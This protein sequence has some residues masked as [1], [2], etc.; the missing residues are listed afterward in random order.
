MAAFIGT[1]TEKGGGD[2][3]DAGAMSGF[4]VVIWLVAMIVLVADKF[5]RHQMH[6]EATTSNIEKRFPFP[7]GGSNNGE[8]P[9]AKFS[10]GGGH[11]PGLY[12]ALL[13]FDVKSM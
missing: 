11:V 8:G 7:K 13:I 5:T 4:L 10:E 9:K 12:I 1:C 3:D 2:K 6:H